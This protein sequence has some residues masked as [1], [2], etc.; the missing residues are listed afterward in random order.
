MLHDC[1]ECFKTR[2][3]DALQAEGPI[4]SKSFVQI[5]AA[6]PFA[7]VVLHLYAHRQRVHS[8]AGD[9]AAAA[10]LCGMIMPREVQVDQFME[11]FTAYEARLRGYI[12]S[13]VPRWSDAEEISQRCSFLLWKKFDQFEVGTNF[14][15]WACKIARLEVKD[16]RKRSARERVIFSDD[17]VDAVA[18]R[19]IEM[20]EEFP[21]RTKALQKCIEQLPPKQRELL[22]L[23]YDEQ[24]TVV[25]VAK[26]IN[27]PIEGVYKSLTRIRQALHFCIDARLQAGE[28]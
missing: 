6:E 7:E 16:F 24:R 28:E 1:F 26:F 20:E 22:R 10:Y 15:A 9:V 17:F 8:R 3:C 13:L 18:D 14:Y 12:L 4:R 2:S 23:R 21:E 25:A 19:A 5:E 11:L 27:K